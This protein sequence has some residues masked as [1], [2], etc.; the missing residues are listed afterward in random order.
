MLC[1]WIFLGHPEAWWFTRRKTRFLEGPPFV[2]LPV[3]TT[4]DTPPGTLFT[5]RFGLVAFQSF[6]FTGNTPYDGRERGWV[7]QSTFASASSPLRLFDCFLLLAGASLSSSFTAV[8]DLA[9]EVRFRGCFGF[10]A[11]F[12]EAV[13]A[14]FG[15]SAA[16]K[17]DGEGIVIVS[18][19]WRARF[20]PLAT[21]KE[22]SS[23]RET[24][25]IE[26]VKTRWRKRYHADKLAPLPRRWQ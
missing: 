9:T 23:I 22:A 4:R 20:H 12:G 21:T 18:A 24:I 3:S 13:L 5:G 19:I 11:G 15:E 16:K 8:L 17:T 26:S 2:V 7:T 14:T 6:G 25:I 10:G 1:R